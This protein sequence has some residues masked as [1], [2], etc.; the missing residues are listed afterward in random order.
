MVALV[1]RYF[2]VR[3]IISFLLVVC[4]IIVGLLILPL[5]VILS[6]AVLPFSPSDAFLM[7]PLRSLQRR[8]PLGDARSFNFPRQAV[9]GLVHSS[10]YENSLAIQACVAWILID[11]KGVG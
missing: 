2:Y 6:I 9:D 10:T 7:G 11:R 8:L 1:V 3:M 5:I 4:T